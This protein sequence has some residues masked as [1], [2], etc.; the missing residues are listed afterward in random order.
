MAEGYYWA[1]NPEDNTHFIVLFE[2]GQ[3]YTVGIQ[4]PL[5]NFDQHQIIK[6]I[7]EP[8]H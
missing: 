5:Q 1:R 4:Q 2:D 8:S 3:W 6:R 7:E